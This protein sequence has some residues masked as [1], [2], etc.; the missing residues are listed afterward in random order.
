MDIIKIQNGDKTIQ[1]ALSS[2]RGEKYDVILITPERYSSTTFSDKE[3]AKKEVA[4]L[5][6]RYKLNKNKRK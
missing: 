1:I 3:A 6:R 5:K 2:K 4:K